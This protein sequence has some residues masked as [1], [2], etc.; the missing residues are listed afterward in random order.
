MNVDDSSCVYML[1]YLS[2]SCTL[3]CVLCHAIS[4]SWFQLIC[5]YC[6]HS[7]RSCIRQRSIAVSQLLIRLLR[8]L[9]EH[10]SQLD[11]VLH[12]ASQ[13]RTR[14]SASK[15]SYKPTR[16]V[17]RRT[18]QTQGLMTSPHY[19]PITIA[20]RARFEYDST[21]IRLRFER[22]TTSY[23]ELCAFEQ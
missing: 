16:P 11:D 23:E 10:Q 6:M 3:F 13:P 17:R 15:P 4:R 22:D 9:S 5:K 21:T 14:K 18:S 20:I 7:G 12:V 1:N 19:G 2:Q 8:L